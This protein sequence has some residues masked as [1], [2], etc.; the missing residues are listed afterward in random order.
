MGFSGK[1]GRISL[2]TPFKTTNVWSREWAINERQKI[3]HDLSGKSL[4]VS[5]IV[6]VKWR[7]F[8]YPLP[9]FGTQKN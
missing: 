4:S 9:R 1:V 3:N 6:L 8:H 5:A 2:G 7:F